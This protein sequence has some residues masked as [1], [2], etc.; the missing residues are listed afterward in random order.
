MD[1]SDNLFS[2]FLQLIHVLIFL[3]D[4]ILLF[5]EASERDDKIV[6]EV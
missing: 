1:R 2:D 4:G 6:T 5:V 3:N